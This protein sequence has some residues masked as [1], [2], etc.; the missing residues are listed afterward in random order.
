M[1]V[2][3]HA[4][5]LRGKCPVHRGGG[6]G[7]VGHRLETR[8]KAVTQTLHQHT[9]IARQYL[10]SD[11]A[12]KVCPAPNGKGFVLSHEPHQFHEID[13]QHDSL[14][15]HERDARAR[16][17]KSPSPGGLLLAFFRRLIVHVEPI[18][19]FRRYI[20]DGMEPHARAARKA[21]GIKSCQR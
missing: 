6:I 1:L 8:Q 4:D 20:L 17:N 7:G 16:Y 11:D 15:A 14:L 10:G 19:R 3:G 13:Q 18:S 9:A 2:F 12:D 21:I 5:V